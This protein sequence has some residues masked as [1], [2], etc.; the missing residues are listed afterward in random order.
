MF[1]VSEKKTLHG[2]LLV[3]TDLEIIGKK[4]DQGK[5]QLDLTKEFY[6]GQQKSAEEAKELLSRAR[7]IHFTG[8]QAILLG[9]RA[10][11]IDKEKILRIANIPHAE[12]VQEG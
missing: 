2:L 4:F 1:I 11:L 3:I 8:E 10:E 5:L 12:I 6:K 9:L 7:Y